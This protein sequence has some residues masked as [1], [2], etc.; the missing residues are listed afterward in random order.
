[1]PSNQFADKMRRAK[2]AR[3]DAS[4]TRIGA[5]KDVKA[6]PDLRKV[7]NEIRHRYPELSPSYRYLLVRLAKIIMSERKAHDGMLDMM[8][9]P[10]PTNS[11]IN[12][13]RQVWK[14][15]VAERDRVE[16]KIESALSG[17]AEIEEGYG[18]DGY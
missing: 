9:K 14:D 10:R 13:M 1:M 3:G 18:D 8:A 2:V 12:T 11:S 15:S 4:K 16:S 5:M 17:G 6:D 7:F